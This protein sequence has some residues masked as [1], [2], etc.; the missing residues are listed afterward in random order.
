MSKNR[1]L[2][3]IISNNTSKIKSIFTDSDSIVNST[4]GSVTVSSGVEV[5]SSV[6]LLPGSASDGDQALVTS[7]NRLYIYSD[8]GWY[9]I[10]IINNFNPQWITQPDSEYILDLGNIDSEII[11]TVLANDSDDVPIT[12]SVVLDSD[13][14]Q[15]INIV[16]D[17]DK[18]NVWRVTL[19][20]SDQ[21]SGS[22]T[23]KASDGVNVVNSYSV[24]FS[25]NLGVSIQDAMASGSGIYDIYAADGN[26]A[27]TLKSVYV[28]STKGM[29]YVSFASDGLNATTYPAWQANR[30]LFSQLSSNGFSF[31][32]NW[33]NYGDGVTNNQGGYS[34]PSGSLMFFAAAANVA[35]LTLAT[36]NGPLTS[37][38]SAINRIYHVTSSQFSNQDIY[39]NGSLAQN[40]IST[41]KT[42]YNHSITL[43]S[44][45]DANTVQYRETDGIF[46]IYDIWVKPV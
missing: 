27:G 34:R 12:Y 46:H 37:G 45:T 35:N 4:S 8:S 23:F 11:I 28:D 40:N 13:A 41:S 6:D 21:G 26:D 24:N 15:L 22:V 33:A 3:S 39:V 5:Y 2:S 17:S 20:D 19:Q 10:A 7:T 9:N 36:Y 31:S 43:S 38:G 18:D 44:A 32:P 30:I 16:H 29:L 42:T 1:T 14:N 25:F